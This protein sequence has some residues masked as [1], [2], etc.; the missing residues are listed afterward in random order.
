MSITTIAQ[1]RTD[2]PEFGNS[3]TFPDAQ[4]QFYLN[5]AEA[6]L[7][8]ERWADLWTYGVELYTAHNLSLAQQRLGVAASGGQI[9]A[10]TG[11]ATSK[12]VGSV[13][14]TM[15]LGVAT[16]VGAGTYNL[17]TYGAEFYQLV[18]QV[19]IGGMQL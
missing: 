18:E 16:T 13:S 6:R 19:G 7:S 8:M 17:T 1:F 9:G 14:K 10:T 11:I 3:T 15:D 4:V 2:F 12:A 5:L